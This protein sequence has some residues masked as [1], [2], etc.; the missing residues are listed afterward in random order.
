MVEEMVNEQPQEQPNTVERSAPSVA[1]N[2]ASVPVGDIGLASSVVKPQ[3]EAERKNIEKAI[4]QHRAAQDG[5]RKS[6][7]PVLL[8]I[9]V[10]IVAVAGY[11]VFKPNLVSKVK[12]KTGAVL[13]SK[14]NAKQALVLSHDLKVTGTTGTLTVLATKRTDKVTGVFTRTGAPKSLT[15]A[16]VK[17]QALGNGVLWE[18][19][20]AQ[21]RKGKYTYKAFVRDPKRPDVGVVTGNFIVK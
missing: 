11:F 15:K 17:K 21:L 2:P 13:Q 5:Q 14:K 12:A 1:P 4:E 3:A 20:V 8:V 18:V 19:K 6:I 16:G 10:V 7:I 9:G